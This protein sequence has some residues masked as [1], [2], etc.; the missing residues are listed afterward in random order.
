MSVRK[1]RSPPATAQAMNGSC[2]PAAADAGDQDTTRPYVEANSLL[3]D[4]NR[5]LLR[6]VFF[7][8][9]NKTKY[10]SVGF[11]PSRNYQPLVELGIPKVTPLILTD[12]HVRTLAEHSPRSSTRCGAMNFSMFTMAIF[13]C[14]LF[15]PTRRPFFLQAPRRI[16]R[17]YSYACLNSTI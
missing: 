5:V 8:D 7:L 9:P 12:S 14:I 1:G 13:L 6:R 17:L 16:E 4:P 15:R 3:F 2:I 10:I 11:Y